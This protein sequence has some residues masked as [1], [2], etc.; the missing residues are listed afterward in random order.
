MEI[1]SILIGLILLA[2]SLFFVSAPFR[3]KFRK[4]AQIPKLHVEKE[5]RREM[6]ISALRDLEFDFKTG[7][8]D[9]E[10]YTPLRAQLMA[11]AA[12]LIEQE[13]EEDKKLEELIQARRAAR[14]SSIK[15]DHCGEDVEA[16]QR[17]CAR[18]GAQVNHDLCPAC[19]K[20]IRSGDQFCPSCGRRPEVRVGALVQS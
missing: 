12:Q 11:E 8:V 3:R 16:D 13:Q 15:C 4:D 18:C 2:T 1:S 20:G 17:F 10:D 5:E 6:V 19:G 9:V 7:K 14:K